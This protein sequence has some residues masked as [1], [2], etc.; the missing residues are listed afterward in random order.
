MLSNGNGGK[1]FKF[2]V[3]DDDKVRPEA[4]IPS[5]K[6]SDLSR[7]LLIL[8]SFGI[9]LEK[10]RNLPDEP[11][12]EIL[13]ECFALLR[14]IGVIDNTKDKELTPI[15]VEAS[16]FS[17][18][19][20]FFA[21]ATAKF[22]ENQQFAFLCSLIIE[23]SR[24][25]ITDSRSKLLCK[26]F[27][28]DSDVVTL[29]DSVCEAS[30]GS[31]IGSD[32][33]GLSIGTL[34]MIYLQMENTFVDCVGR[35]AVIESVKWARSQA[36]GTIGMVDKFVS[37]LDHE[38]FLNKR[39][40]EFVHILGAGPG[41]ETMLI[42]KA[43]DIFKIGEA[44]EGDE[45]KS[46]IKITR[47]P[48]WVGLQ[49]PGNV[50]ILS[51]IV[52]EE[53]QFN[54]GLIMHRDPTAS[55]VKPGIVS[56]E[57]DNPSLNSYFFVSL[58][59][60]YWSGNSITNNFISIYHTP[61]P[62]KESSFLIHMTNDGGKTFMNYCPKNV[63]TANTMR[64]AIPLL[65]RLMPFVPRSIMAKLDVP[66][67]AVEVIGEGTA[68]IF[69]TRINFI[70][71]PSDPELPFAYPVNKET[72]EYA[73]RNINEMCKNAPMVRF[74]IT[75][76]CFYYISKDGK[77]NDTKL[78]YPDVNPSIKCV[79]DSYHPSHL[80]LLVSKEY[81]SKPTT[82]PLK[83]L[84][85][86]GEEVKTITNDIEANKMAI[87]AASKIMNGIGYAEHTADVFFVSLSNGVPTVKSGKIPDSIR[88]KVEFKD[89]AIKGGIYPL[90]RCFINDFTYKQELKESIPLEKISSNDSWRN[91]PTDSSARKNLCKQVN[92]AVS[93]YFHV[94]D[95][96]V[97]SQFIGTSILA[98]RVEKL[99]ENLTAH[100][101]NTK[102]FDNEYHPCIADDGIKKSLS[103]I[104]TVDFQVTKVIHE[105]VIQVSVY[106]MRRLNKS[107]DEFMTSVEN[108]FDM[109]GFLRANKIEYID[110]SSKQQKRGI[111]GYVEA[112]FYGMSTGLVFATQI[113]SQ[114]PI[115]S[116]LDLTMT[117]T[118]RTIKGIETIDPRLTFIPDDDSSIIKVT[119]AEVEA[120]KEQIAMKNAG[121]HG[122]KW[123]LDTNFNV[124]IIPASAE[125]AA[126]DMV[127]KVRNKDTDT[128]CLMICDP[129]QI[130]L[131]QSLYSYQ[132]DGSVITH[133]ICRQCMIE[134]F[135][136]Y[137]PELQR[138]IDPITHV[139]IREELAGL[140]TQLRG[141]PFLGSTSEGDEMWPL[142]PIGQ[143]FWALMSDPDTFGPEL[144]SWFT[145]VIDLTI[146]TARS[147]ITFCPNHP[148]IPLRTP[149]NG[150]NAKCMYCD[151]FFHG[152][153]K[154]WHEMGKVCKKTDLGMKKCPNC[155]VDTEKNGGCNHI[156]CEY[157]KKHWCY[158]CAN[159]PIFETGDQCYKHMKAVHG[160]YY[161]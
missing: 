11:N 7:H 106:N 83:W 145:A 96:N 108:V 147:C 127:R 72:L 64:T 74:S 148:D 45:I 42:Y 99:P 67:C 14:K 28:R 92:T 84:P 116:R 143:A 30:E 63:D 50:Y 114:F 122:N 10:Q 102:A 104:K 69:N 125:A 144:K 56:I 153:C 2:T 68:N 78:K 115:L 87:T 8:R 151:M 66:L 6:R 53:S 160:G 130:F 88:N 58:F 90:Y 95:K 119:P 112:E 24:N 27:N 76:E 150:N 100:E 32:D 19:S 142:I 37:L 41:C 65:A 13:N 75:G 89:G 9:K 54:H 81:P 105:P 149:K 61:Y 31:T 161:T 26:N 113:I 60:G 86:L 103:E 98:I 71:D 25:L 43:D 38:N 158:A 77:E 152:E 3:A 48:G 59:E 79:F 111:L 159:S 121:V 33:W 36:G 46:K 138:I 132:K 140:N 44:K 23:N 101:V 120:L 35:N 107:E 16:K 49:S 39:K 124:L 155:L 51:L 110:P 154:E 73:Q 117:R 91:Y 80:V 94:E 15:G 18:V 12:H 20:P 17:F 137:I 118:M 70:D 123:N 133:A 139:I 136:E 29:L 1:Y 128:T 40:A 109:F 62:E 34:H 141:I 97:M 156:R 82:A 135:R 5:V 85:A 126:K 47:R 93:N 134:S 55:V 146:K 131:P 21:V 4:L 129:P 52:E 157:C 22:K 57:V